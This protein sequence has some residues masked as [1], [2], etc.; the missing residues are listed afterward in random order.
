M[1]VLEGDC[2]Q[3]YCINININ[4]QQTLDVLVLRPR[5]CAIDAISVALVDLELVLIE[6]DGS[7]YRVNSTSV[8][9]FGAGYRLARPLDISTR[10]CSLC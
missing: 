7:S 4:S 5:S 2:K 8:D 10:P 1:N 9:L 3:K 6:L